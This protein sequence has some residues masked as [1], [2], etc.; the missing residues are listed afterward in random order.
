MWL[1]LYQQIKRFSKSILFDKQN[2]YSYE[3]IIDIVMLNGKQLGVKLQS[4]TKCAILCDAELNTAIAI[5]SCW[6]ANMIPIPMSKNYG[7]KHYKA[8]I[9]LTKPDLL[10][11]DDPKSYEFS[12]FM[13]DINCKKFIGRMPPIQI[14]QELKDIAIIMC[15]SGTTGMPKG[16]MITFAGLKKNIL[17]IAKYFAIKTNETILIA[18][19]LYHCAVLTGEFLIALYNGLNVSFT[20]E[21]YN[22]SNILQLAVKH[23]VSVLCGTPT[24][25]N[26][27]SIL[28]KRNNIIHSIKKMAIS[29]ECLHENVAIN[30][31]KSFPKTEIYNVYG[32][33]EASPRISYLPPE[34]FD[35]YSESVGVPLADIQIK[36]SD[37]SNNELPVNFHGFIMVKTPC[38]MKGYYRNENATEK[39]IINGWL[40][41]GDIGYKDENGYLYILSRTDDMIIK[42]GMNI[43]PKEIENQIATIKQV[44]ECVVYGTKTDIGQTITVDLVLMDDYKTIPKKEM[45]ILLSTVLPA[46]QMPSEINIVDSLNR[47]AS[48]KLVRARRKNDNAR[49]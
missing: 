34:K 22:P 20:D 35:N 4:S 9:E 11:T 18:R 37:E 5:L 6:N 8:I 47:N 30:I 26:H 14:D 7:E 15:T 28:I 24:L 44:Q 23:N 36:I 33:T 29:G 13:Y 43:Y 40:N 21:K 17:S 25:L 3:Q 31:R 46:Y 1:F 2:T 19:P 16:T 42:G 38:I 41:T 48:G 10:I 32:L 39:V 45:M 27:L 12:N 49:N